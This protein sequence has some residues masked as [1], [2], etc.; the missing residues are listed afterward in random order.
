MAKNIDH[1]LDPS[2]CVYA[3]RASIACIGSGQQSVADA[4]A[5]ARAAVA[6]ISANQA[7]AE[8]RGLQVSSI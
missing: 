4:H 8:T 2:T 6:F 3:W 7:L 5:G 1:L